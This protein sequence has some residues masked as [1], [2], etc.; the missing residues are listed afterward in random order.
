MASGLFVTGT[1]TAVGKTLVAA[2]LVALLKER[3]F[4]V[5]VM[6]PL[7]SGAPS[8]G[9]T[10]IPRDAVYL[11]EIA[12]VNDDLSLINPYCFH[13]PLA[14]AV[15]AK[16][17]GVKVDLERIASAFAQLN[18]LHPI[19]VVEGAGGLLVPI[20]EGRLLPDLI[21][22]LQLPILVVARSTLGTINHTLLTLEY[23]R[24]EMIPV[25]GVILSKSTP[26][27]DP[28]EEEN[29]ELI[30]TIGCIPVL[31]TIPYLR[32]CAGVKG[33]RT[34]LSEIIVQHIDTKKLFA[35]LGL[36]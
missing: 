33:N 10:P 2:G 16:R 5:G 22:M 3:G 1:D 21:K 23:C 18:G 28:S 19:M 7:E 4:D 36:P 26:D 31:G 11:K 13:S 24:R 14:P 9:S 35:A 8:F 25:L 6:K 17:E 32:D 20:A 15:A 30:A 34:F 12:G 27:P 29:A